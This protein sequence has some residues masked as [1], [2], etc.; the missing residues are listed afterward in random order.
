[1]NNTTM[2]DT[3][4][5]FWNQAYKELKPMTL[6]KSDF[7][8][9][10]DFAEALKYLGDNA[11]EVLEIGVGSG[12]GIFAC[13]ALGTKV[14]HLTG[15]DPSPHVVEFLRGTCDLSNINNVTVLQED[16][17][18]LESLPTDS[19]DGIIVSNV[20]DVLEEDISKY[21]INQINRILKPGGNFVLKINFYLTKEIIERTKAEEI[22]PN[23]YTI[24]GVIRSV[25]RTTEEWINKFNGFSLIKEGT[26]AR[27]GDG[28]LDRVL[29]FKKR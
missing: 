15:I 4:K 6:E 12:R 22:R 28:P 3:I 7:S 13:Q 26:F 11:L 9:E 14:K 17:L 21:I 2:T 25:N 1:M 16:H 20:L 10:D 8:V 18:Y 23:V 24:N 29:L 19:V 5:D 27:L